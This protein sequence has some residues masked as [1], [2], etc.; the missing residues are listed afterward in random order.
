MIGRQS[1]CEPWRSAIVSAVE[2]GLSGQRIYQDLVAEH[3]F[4]G[5]YYSVRRF[6]R[7]LER[8]GEHPVRRL[9][10]IPGDEAQVDFGTGAPI[11][12]PDGKRRKTHVFRV[13]LSFSRKAHSI[14]VNRQTTDNFILCLENAFY[15]F[16]GVPKTIVLDNLRAAVSKCDWFEP[17]L[18][19]K[20]LAFAEHYKSTFLPTRAY[21]PQHKGKVEN[22]IGYVKD[23]ALKG[24]RFA[25]LAEENDFLLNW[26]R[27]VADVRIH[28]TTRRQVAKLFE[29]SERSRLQPLP[30]ERF[31]SFHE[32]RRKVHRDG[33][34]EVAK[35]YYTA[36]PEYLG[37]VVWVRWDSRIV[38]IFNH[39]ME[40][41]RTHPRNEPGKFSTNP[42]DIASEKISG[43]ERNAAYY[44]DRASWIGPGCRLWSEGVVRTAGVRAVRILMGL[45]SLRGRFELAAIEKACAIA[46]GYG[47]FRLK[48]V[49]QLIQRKE[50]DVQ[51]RFDFIEQLTIIRSMSD[52]QQFVHD[53]F[54]RENKA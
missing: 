44:L 14:V 2:A 49:R 54:Q 8:R 20:V 17:E 27:T 13:V 41:I 16:G 29:E 23:N 42:L 15:H 51:E 24:R 33:H 11:V 46:H 9:E 34:V 1:S 4:E 18:N 35:A 19:P 3:G 28:G 53:A 39:R 5:S 48:T 21:H 37:Q 7:R 12:G 47:S 45:L 32:Q 25:S 50:A 31:P 43:V 26:E 6:V 30:L 38:R 40:Q 10:T 52:Y 22:A 36:P